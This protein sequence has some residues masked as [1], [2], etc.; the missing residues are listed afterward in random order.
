MLRVRAVTVF[1]LSL[2]ALLALAGVS[3]AETPGTE[4]VRLEDPAGQADE[5]ELDAVSDEVEGATGQEDASAL[6]EIS[7][8]LGSAA[9]A[10]AD[11]VIASAGAIADVSV[12]IGHGLWTG[13][14][15]VGDGLVWTVTAIADGLAWTGQMLWTGLATTGDAIAWL[16][17]QIGHGTVAIGKGLWSGTTAIGS[18]L[19]WTGQMLWT[20]LVATGDLLVAGSLGAWGLLTQL[21]AAL[22]GAWPEDPR[23]QAAAASAAGGTAAAMGAAAWYTKAWRY[24]RYLPFLAP[25]YTRLS[26]ED[27][28]DHPMRQEIHALIQEKPGIHMSELGR[29]LEASWG[30]LLHHLDKL[31]KARLILSEDTSGKRCFFLPGQVSREHKDILPALENETARAIAEHFA[32]NPGA[33]Q[34]DAAD[35]LDLSAALVSWHVKRLEKAGVLTR[36]RE[37]RTKKVGVTQAAMT[38]MAAA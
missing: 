35:A 26:R 20:G 16:G 8:L 27:L 14:T 37:G 2:A 12:A 38:A 4:D 17:V 33:T 36:T 7:E 6:E 31:E 29:E 28:L 19:A 21:G 9:S 22:I 25:L 34:K 13:I 18:G 30:T 5:I 32:D 24:A 23:H 1:A 3:G 10:V 11:A 15:A